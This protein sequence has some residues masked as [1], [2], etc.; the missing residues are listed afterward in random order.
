MDVG[1][2]IGAT[3][4]A[5]RHGPDLREEDHDDFSNYLEDRAAPYEAPVKP[6]AATDKAPQSSTAD[7]AAKGEDPVT[8]GENVR[9][10]KSEP[11]PVE[12]QPAKPEMATE[13]PAKETSSAAVNAASGKTTT[14][15]HAPQAVLPVSPAEA[16]A[17]PAIVP[18]GTAPQTGVP[19]NESASVK[20]DQ[21][22]PVAAE[23]SPLLSPAKDNVAAQA[24]NQTANQV[25]APVVAQATSSTKKTGPS[26]DG[27]KVTP[28]AASENVAT[29]KPAPTD[30]LEKIRTEATNRMS[31]KDILSSK[32]AELLQ[33]GK[34]KISLASNGAAKSF[35]S[36]LASSTNLVTAAT[37]DATTTPFGMTVQTGAVN[38]E[39]PL[40]QT[41]A[42]TSQVQ[43]AMPG[44]TAQSLS[45][46]P[47]AAAV[48]GVD[49]TAINSTSQASNAAR[50]AGQTPV[51][52]QVSLQISNAVKEGVDR[53]KISLHPS[54]LGRVDVKLEI[55][56]D[57]RVLA[58][59]AV[60]KQETLDLLQRDSRSLEKALQ[61]AGFE[62]GSGSLNF[63][64]SKD[65]Q[66]QP[67]DFAG[68]DPSLPQLMESDDLPP[69]APSRMTA[70]GNGN[71]DIQV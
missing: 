4:T 33:E 11:A 56:Q 41:V 29:V 65:G 40:A 3:S 63:G 19:A 32:V 39:I 59:I 1:Q 28:S 66:E 34:G 26:T 25:A 44:D 53:I 47:P 58:A 68:S 50:I 46:T 60:D 16:T 43:A 55:G 2:I 36:T 9:A 31:E 57:G 17:N 61:D 21:Q 27:N 54:E 71:L 6:A 42:G 45:P 7:P 14:P 30:A 64:L 15:L 13:S 23:K 18:A 8:E 37:A 51:A 69:V 52:E 24:A 62:T 5:N 12:D 35:Q 38:G 49:A 22:A 70:D 10:V 48:Q 67:M 20:K